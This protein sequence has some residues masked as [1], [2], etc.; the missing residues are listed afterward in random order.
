MWHQVGFLA[1]AFQVFK[2]QGMSVDLISTSETNVTVS[3]D[4]TAN[5]LDPAA[6]RAPLGGARRA[7]P[8]RDPRTLRLAEPARPQYPRHP[9]RAR[10]GVRAVPGPQDLSGE[11]GGQRSELHLRDRRIAGRPPGASAARAA[12]PEHRLRQGAGAHLAAAVRAARDGGRACRPT[13]GRTPRKRAPAAGDRARASPRPSYTTW[14][15]WMPRLRRCTRV[16]SVARWAYSMKANWHPAIL[17]RIYAAGLTLECVSQGELEHAFAAVPGLAP[18]RV[19]FT[20]NFAPR[21]EYEY[22]FQLG[23]RVT[24]DNLYPLKAWPELF[25][26]REIFVRI[27]PGLRARTPSPRA[28]RRACTRNSACRSAEADELAALARAHRRA[29]RRAARAHRQRHLRCRQLD[30]DRRAAR[31]SS[32]TRFPDVG[33]VDLGGGIGVP[34]QAGQAGIDLAALDAGVA[35]LQAAISARSNSGWSRAVSWSRKAGV[36]VAH[37]DPVEEQGRRALRRHRDRDEFPHPPGAVWSASRY[38]QSDAARAS[39]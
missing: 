17:R 31:A 21:A 15:A 10:F 19:L 34:E 37:G 12:D 5:T 25:R 4:P 16:K 18:E 36:L 3:L 8:R 23:V 2:Q 6:L 20:P 14:R 11:P 35:A 33:V 1:D 32:R 24:L 38:P 7:V 22:G 29:R 9:A 27:D 28:H 26:G 30:R 13:G 39:R